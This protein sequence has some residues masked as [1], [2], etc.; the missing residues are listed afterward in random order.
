MEGQELEIER[1]LVR[2][3][4]DASSYLKM[5]Q[6]A[7]KAT[8][9]VEDDLGKASD[10]AK[11][12]G[13]SIKSFGEAL[14]AGLASYGATRFLHEIFEEF[15]RGEDVALKLT[16]T[17]EANGREVDKLTERYENFA[18]VMQDLSTLGDTEVK[19]MLQQAEALG[20]TGASAMRAVKNVV[21]ARSAGIHG[22]GLRQAAGLEHGQVGHRVARALG[23]DT[24]A[25]EEE[26][27]IAAQEKLAGAFKATQAEASTTTGQ[28]KQFHNVLGNIYEDLGKTVDSV[29]KP[30]VKGIKDLATWFRD[31]SGPMKNVIKNTVLISAALVSLT[32][33]IVAAGIAFNTFFGG[34]GLIA[35]GVVAGIVAI[36]F[37]L[38]NV[39]EDLGGFNEVWGDVQREVDRFVRDVGPMLAEVWGWVKPTA[40]ELLRLGV[41]V[42]KDQLVKTLEGAI[43]AVNALKEAFKELKNEMATLGPFGKGIIDGIF[44]GLG[45]KVARGIQAGAKASAKAG[46]N[47]GNDWAE[48][49]NK[50]SK[51][52]IEKWEAALFGS[53]EHMART[54]AFQAG[55][56]GAGS[57]FDAAAK[58]LHPELERGRQTL[59]AGTTV[60]A[61]ERGDVKQDEMTRVLKEILEVLRK[62]GGPLGFGPAGLQ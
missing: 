6:D 19:S 40:Q 42:I 1:L 39:I 51:G 8:K 4:G 50:G 56:P 9:D 16:A 30:F 7:R 47:M 46:L 29:V 13:D 20:L 25:S 37:V 3:V 59:I 14:T 48:E 60:E 44:A 10:A 33:G 11:S 52:G 32:A 34:I 61:D 45:L 43:V 23:I 17:M 36:S 57:G 49:F 26:Q 18:H 54:L 24:S 62:Q 21:A 5:L 38:A 41:Y 55:L 2:L 28:I 27:A 53:A 12:F 31:L 22:F 58:F 35:A 15:A